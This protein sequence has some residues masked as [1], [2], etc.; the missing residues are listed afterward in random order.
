MEAVFHHLTYPVAAELQYFARFPPPTVG[1]QKTLEIAYWET[2]PVVLIAALSLSLSKQP[3]RE[4]PAP[5]VGFR[6]LG[7]MLYREYLSRRGETLVWAK[8]SSW[9]GGGG[10]CRRLNQDL[11]L[12]YIGPCVTRVSISFRI[13]LTVG[14]PFS[15]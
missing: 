3:L 15:Y 12:K 4:H 1:P 8:M 6:L 10:S 9:G 14:S 13:F 11:N 7:A 5:C 2:K